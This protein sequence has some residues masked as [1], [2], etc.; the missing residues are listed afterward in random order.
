LDRNFTEMKIGITGATG[1]IGSRLTALCNRSGFETVGFSRRPSTGARLF[2]LTAPP[3]L[4]GLDAIVNLAGESVLG[5][6]TAEKKRRIRESR[7]V[8]TRRLVEAMEKMARRPSVL[9]NASA[10]GYYGDTG[11]RLVD[12]FSAPGS[13]FLA[14]VCREWEA[15]AASAEALG[16]RVVFVRIGFVLGHGGA[17]KVIAPLFKLGLGGKLGSGRQ[18]MSAVH[19]EDV[20]GIIFWALKNDTLSGPV[21]AVMAE[22]IRNAEFTSELARC[23][24][25]PAVLPAPAFALRLGLG[26]LSRLMLDSTRVV[27][28]VAIETGYKY[29]FPTLPAALANAVSSASY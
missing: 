3:D 17:L 4:D 19:V 13:G 14:E 26:E 12:E 1:F 21:N 2:Q 15:E 9:V 10:I 25:R 28:K 27:P 22:P 18:W 8:G 23:L 6:W 24:S 16:V 29:Q 11:E 20:A 5:L 7:V